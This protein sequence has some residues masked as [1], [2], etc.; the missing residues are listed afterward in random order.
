MLTTFLCRTVDENIPTHLNSCRFVQLTV[1]LDLATFPLLAD[2]V[3]PGTTWSKVR[4]QC[5]VQDAMNTPEEFSSVSAAWCVSL[6][7]SLSLLG[8]GNQG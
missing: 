2:D 7:R 8:F 6:L 4:A 3:S 5:V 1:G